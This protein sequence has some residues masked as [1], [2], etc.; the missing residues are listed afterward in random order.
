MFFD[1][2]IST[3]IH[4]QP[5]VL[6]KSSDLVISQNPKSG[7]NSVVLL[8]YLAE[9]TT[10]ILKLDLELTWS[11]TDNWSVLLEGQYAH[12]VCNSAMLGNV[13]HSVLPRR[14]CTCGV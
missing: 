11:E 6:I 14:T 7:Y 13:M 1:S 8:H 9:Y 12:V 5:F 2:T 3:L 10:P 4:L